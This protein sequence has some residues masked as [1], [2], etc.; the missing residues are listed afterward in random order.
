MC[1]SDLIVEIEKPVCRMRFTTETEGVFDQ[2]LDVL[3]SVTVNFQE[4]I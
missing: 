3:P 2:S 1:S 4:A